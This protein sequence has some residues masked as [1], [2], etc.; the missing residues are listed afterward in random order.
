MFTVQSE[1]VL[2]HDMPD[3]KNGIERIRG[4]IAQCYNLDESRDSKYHLH[5]LQ[6]TEMG[7]R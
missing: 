7:R 2:E 6:L 3:G 1:C 5:E 4:E